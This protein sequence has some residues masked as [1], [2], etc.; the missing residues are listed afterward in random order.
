M[1]EIK[2]S[3]NSMENIVRQIQAFADKIE[4][5]EGG[6]KRGRHEKETAGGDH[7]DLG[8]PQQE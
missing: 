6:K 2:F 7:G 5:K 4:L 1:I 3:G 8:K